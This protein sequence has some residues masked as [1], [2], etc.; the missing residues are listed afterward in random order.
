VERRAE[1][2]ARGTAAC[3]DDQ[4][5]WTT[6]STGEARCEEAACRSSYDDALETGRGKRWSTKCDRHTSDNDEIVRRCKCRTHIELTQT[7]NA[8]QNVGLYK[9]VGREESAQDELLS[10]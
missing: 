1:E 4:D 3:F 5:R 8:A 2:L 10:Y 9:G 6:G 7:E